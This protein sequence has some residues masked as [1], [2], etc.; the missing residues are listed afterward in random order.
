MSR[1]LF[2]RALAIYLPYTWG[3]G[4]ENGFPRSSSLELNVIL[5]KV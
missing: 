2:L 3:E 4:Q 1:P 5:R